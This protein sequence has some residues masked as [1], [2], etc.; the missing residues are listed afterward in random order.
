[1]WCAK[2]FAELIKAGTLTLVGP[3]G[4]RHVFGGDRLAGIAPVV[5]RLHDGSVDRRLA[6]RPALAVGGS[7][8]GWYADHRAGEPV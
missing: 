2:L 4:S 5:V 6:L 8:Y 3:D 7:L 1:M